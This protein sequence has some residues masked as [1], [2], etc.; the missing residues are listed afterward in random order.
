MRSNGLSLIETLIAMV[1][2]A[3]T[4][5][6]FTSLIVGN[7]QQ[8][9]NSGARTGGTQLLNYLGRR[10]IAGDSAVIPSSATA[11]REWIYGEVQSAFPDLIGQQ[12]SNPALYRATVENL[13]QQSPITGISLTAYRVEVCWQNQGNESCVR[14][15]TF[16]PDLPTP[17]TPGT[18]PILT[19]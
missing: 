5:T 7:M 19:N 12:F 1:V 13:G 4:L 15:L 17:G 6:A 16:G 3:I 2:L 14:T 18:Q 10:V 9:T 11:P 8:N